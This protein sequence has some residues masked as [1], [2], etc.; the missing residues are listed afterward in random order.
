M[1]HKRADFE[2]LLVQV[3]ERSG[4]GAALVE[5]D[6]WVTEALR[7]I[8]DQ[9]RD[10]VVFKGGTSLSKAHALIDRFSEDIDLLIV[11]DPDSSGSTGER[12]RYMKAIAD[13]VG[14]VDGLTLRSAPESSSKGRSRTVKFDYEPRAALAEGMESTVMLEMGTRG[15]P[16]PQDPR[17]MSSM[18]GAALAAAGETDAGTETLNMIVLEP[19]RTLVE[20]LSALHSGCTRFVEGDVTALRRISRHYTDIDAILQSDGITDFVSG[21]DYEPLIIDVQSLSSV[22]FPRTHCDLNTPRFGESIALNPTPELLDALERDL[23]NNAFIYFLGV[24]DLA[25]V[26]ARLTTLREIL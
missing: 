19:S 2:D 20:K 16:K 8:A 23:A 22:N 5:K 21:P 7:A 13:A 9:F 18:V 12:D 6:Y 11:V 10:G 17:D 1:L 4:A 26:V 15:G 25:E 3:G 24:P 14:K